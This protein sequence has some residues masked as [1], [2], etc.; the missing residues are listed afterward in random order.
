MENIIMKCPNCGSELETGDKFCTVCGA[1]IDDGNLLET[2]SNGEMIN[3][4]AMD[5]LTYVSKSM[6]GTSKSGVNRL[7]RR[8]FFGFWDIIG[9]SFIGCI[10]TAFLYGLADSLYWESAS[11]FNILNVIFWICLI[12]SLIFNLAFRLSGMG[13]SAVDQAMQESFEKLKNRANSRFNVDADQVGEIEPIVMLGVGAAPTITQGKHGVAKNVVSTYMRFKTFFLLDFK[14][15]IKI[16]TKAPVDGFKASMDRTAR[17]LLVQVTVYA[18]TDSQLLI[19]TGNMDIATGIVYEE[20]VEEV[21]YSDINAIARHDSL[22]VFRYGFFGK[23]YFIMKSVVLDI[24]GTTKTASF[25]TRVA[26]DIEASLVGMESYIREK[27]NA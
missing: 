15:I 6:L 8:Y 7:V 3:K 24:C 5:T 18:F 14:R 1:R 25:D 4:V 17:Y 21:F 2:T 13:K 9:I 11:F 22:D 26:G 16:H 20:S 19:Y 10:V 12:V 27:K 23:Q